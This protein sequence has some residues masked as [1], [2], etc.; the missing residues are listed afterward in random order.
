VAEAVGATATGAYVIEKVCAVDSSSPRRR[1]I[2][3][4]PSTNSTSSVQVPSVAT[5]SSSGAR[6]MSR[7]TRVPAG[8][9]PAKVIGAPATTSPS[10][11]V[12]TLRSPTDAAGA[13][14]DAAV[15]PDSEAPPHA[16]M[17]S[18]AT[19]ASARSRFDI[20]STQWML[21]WPRSVADASPRCAAVVTARVSRRSVG[22]W[23]GTALAITVAG[24][25]GEPGLSRGSGSASR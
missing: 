22:R 2:S 14:D 17:P 16:A 10:D 9:V 24:R 23:K 20:G 11:G 5:T 19:S 6:A 12:R 3:L 1:T 8:A 25:P 4:T 21:R 18:A 13:T 15:G 7:T